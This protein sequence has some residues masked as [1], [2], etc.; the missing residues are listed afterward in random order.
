VSL[1]DFILNL[2]TLWLWLSW[3]SFGADPLNKTTPATL[4]GTLRRAEPTRL[5]GWHFLAALA[6][7]LFLRALLY[8][9]IGPAVN[10][11]PSVR[12][13]SIALS[14][15]SDFLDRMLLFSALSFIIAL[16]VFYLYMLL[17]SLAA[18]QSA[19]TN[20]VQRFLGVQLGIVSRWPSALKFLLPLLIG[21]A[22]WLLLNPLLAT[23]NIVPSATPTQRAE[24]ALLI[25]LGAYLAWKH[26]IVVIL[27]LALLSSYVYLGNHWFWGFISTASHNLL[28]PFKW[29]PLRFGKVDLSPLAGV[30]AV[31][32][33]AYF[34]ERGLIRL[35]EQ[36]AL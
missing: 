7:L 29:L 36:F 10:W 1:I 12:L 35:F 27:L 17:L 9:Q 22:C 31:L 21:A 14:F 19:E 30:I 2:V 3:R 25:G 15:R 34:G 26:L 24:Q 11:T 5:R 4:A 20:P 13:V 32:L 18:G 23:L 6:A 33:L 28:T 8:W 16:A